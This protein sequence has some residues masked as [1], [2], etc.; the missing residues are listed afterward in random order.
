MFEAK[1]IDTNLEMSAKDRVKYKDL[2]TALSV[3]DILVA[4]T[5]LKIVP[6]GYYTMQVHNDKSENT[7]Y[8]VF[9]IIGEDGNRYYTSSE[10]LKDSFLE[11]FNELNGTDEEWGV[12]VV[13]IQSKNYKGEFFTCVVF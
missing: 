4:D 7:D 6:T 10:S 3:A 9:V 13:P 5:E 11:I 2:T 8:S 1:I 12:Q